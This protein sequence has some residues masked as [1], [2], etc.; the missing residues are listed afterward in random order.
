[1]PIMTLNDDEKAQLAVALD[2]PKDALNGK[3]PLN[4]EEN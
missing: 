3:L 4:L 2:L 1:M